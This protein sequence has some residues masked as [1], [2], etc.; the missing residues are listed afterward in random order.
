MV[1]KCPNASKPKFVETIRSKCA[2]SSCK[3]YIQWE[4][5]N[6]LA[7]KVMCE[8]LIFLKIFMK[9]VSFSCMMFFAKNF[10]IHPMYILLWSA[11]SL[12]QD[13]P[14][15]NFVGYFR[16]FHN[17]FFFEILLISQWCFKRRQKPWQ[18]K[19]TALKSYSTYRR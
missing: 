13:P 5:P 12:K 15:D 18:I 17:F 4:Y 16:N 19:A 10:S 2:D 1:E 9:F 11:R 6:I 8:E 7:L 3:Q 14:C